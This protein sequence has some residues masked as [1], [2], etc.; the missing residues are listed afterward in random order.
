MRTRGGFLHVPACGVRGASWVCGSLFS[1]NWKM[2]TFLGHQVVEHSC[3]PAALLERL[4]LSP[5]AVPRLRDAPSLR[6]RSVLGVLGAAAMANVLPRCLGVDPDRHV[7]RVTLW[8]PSPEGS[9]GPWMPSVSRR[10]VFR[11][12]FEQLFPCPCRLTLTSV[13]THCGFG[14]FPP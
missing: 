12:D 2:W 13:R 3:C 4:T 8:L 5:A 6:T 14:G 7:L 10:N 1:S 11:G 9:A